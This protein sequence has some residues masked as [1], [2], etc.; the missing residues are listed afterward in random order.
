MIFDKK[1]SN[2]KDLKASQVRTIWRDLKLTPPGPI[3]TIEDQRRTLQVLQGN[4]PSQ[5]KR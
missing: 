3:T 1:Q 5:P 4:K 2:P